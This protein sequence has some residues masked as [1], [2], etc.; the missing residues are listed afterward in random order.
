[1]DKIEKAKQILE[2]QNQNHI[3]V[4]NEKMAEQVLNIDFEQ[5]KKL[6]TK[7]D[8]KLKYEDLKPVKAINP[9]KIPKEKIE[10]YIKIGE[11]EVKNKKFAVAIMAGGQGTRLRTLWTKRDF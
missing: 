8:E 6:Y 1:M 7:V 5:L 3:K 10:E 11:K 9:D 2:A 4:T